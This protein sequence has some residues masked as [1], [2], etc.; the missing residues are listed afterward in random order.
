MKPNRK[1]PVWASHFARLSVTKPSL[2]FSPANGIE[3]EIAQGDLVDVQEMRSLFPYHEDLSAY[4]AQK[5]SAWIFS[6]AVKTFEVSSVKGFEINGEGYLAVGLVPITAVPDMGFRWFA[7]LV[8][9]LVCLFL[10]SLW[11]NAQAANRAELCQKWGQDCPASATIQLPA[12]ES[13]PDVL[14]GPTQLTV[15]VK[16]KG[17]P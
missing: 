7:G 1:L 4:L 9:C 2:V 14:P 6:G 3:S 5:E 11:G 10:G 8:A 17:T 16:A 15:V 13:E 12:P